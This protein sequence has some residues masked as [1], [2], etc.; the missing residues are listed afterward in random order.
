[1]PSSIRSSSPR[2]CFGNMLYVQYKVLPMC[3]GA[4]SNESWVCLPPDVSLMDSGSEMRFSTIYIVTVD[5]FDLDEDVNK[6]ESF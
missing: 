6:D 5:H 4:N 2:G 3:K 1:M